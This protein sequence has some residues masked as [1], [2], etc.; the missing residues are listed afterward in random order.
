MLRNQKYISQ[1]TPLDF[2]LSQPFR[3]ACGAL[4]L[5]VWRQH[6]RMHT[7]S[8]VTIW[9]TILQALCA[10]VSD[11]LCWR[12]IWRMFARSFLSFLG[13]TTLVRVNLVTWADQIFYGSIRLMGGEKWL[14]VLTIWHPRLRLFLFVFTLAFFTHTAR[15]YC[16]RIL[17]STLHVVKQ[18]Q[19]FIQNAPYPILPEKLKPNQINVNSN[20]CRCTVSFIYMTESART[21]CP[22]S[23]TWQ[24][25]FA[26]HNLQPV[27]LQLVYG[28]LTHKTYISL[29]DKL[30]TIKRSSELNQVV[31]VEG[32]H[33]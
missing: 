28:L 20:C 33:H 10:R 3:G 23:N 18:W 5:C 16:Q 29:T 25:H 15:R 21:V 1:A 11:E 14:S 2:Y 27:W 7:G 6:S 12:L 30:A 26:Q 13:C 8:L 24:V 31:T 9:V 4:G 17:A 22:S 19:Q 32:N